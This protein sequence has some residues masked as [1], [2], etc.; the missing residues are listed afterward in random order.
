[1][2]NTTSPQTPSFSYYPGLQK[3]YELNYYNRPPTS[4]TTTGSDQV[5]TWRD[6]SGYHDTSPV[7]DT[8]TE[9]DITHI[10]Q[11]PHRKPTR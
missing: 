4:Y 1:M 6:Q 5:T 2:P 3:G 9:K 10:I 8:G 11:D 7:D